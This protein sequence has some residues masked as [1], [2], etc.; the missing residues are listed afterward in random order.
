MSTEIS[1]SLSSARITMRWNEPYV[2]EGINKK[3]FVSLPK[4]VYRGWKLAADGSQH[5][6]IQL[7]GDSVGQDHVAVVRLET[8]DTLTISMAANA[9]PISL[10]AVSGQTVKLA[11]QASYAVGSE[12][13]A[14][15]VAIP[16]TEWNDLE[17][18]QQ[19]ELVVLG[20]VAVPTLDEV[21]PAADVTHAGRNEAWEAIAPGMV[22]WAP[23]IKNGG[24][25][26]A[27][28][29]QA[30]PWDLSGGSGGTWA[31]NSS[32]GNQ[33]LQLSCTVGGSG[34]TKTA[35]Q[36]LDVPIRYAKHVRLLLKYQAAQTI[37]SG[38]FDATVRFRAADGSFTDVVRTVRSVGA[39][40]SS[41]VAFDEIFAIPF[42]YTQVGGIVLGTDNLVVASSSVALRVDDVQLF[43]ETQ[44][45]LA[46]RPEQ[47]S[48][49]PLVANGMFLTDPSAGAAASTGRIQW[50]STG[51]G[52][53]V[54]GRADGSLTDPQPQL[55]VRGA[56]V[57]SNL[58]V[59][60]GLHGIGIMPNGIGVRGDGTGTGFGVLGVGSGST[61][62]LPTQTHQGVIGIGGNNADGH[63]VVG[64][65]TY[66]GAAG[67]TAGGT[68]HGVIALGGLFG[69]SAVATNANGIGLGGS[70]GDAGYGVQGGI[71]STATNGTGGMFSGKGSG[72]GAIGYASGAGAGVLGYGAWSGT[73][74]F[75]P[76]AGVAGFAGADAPGG[77]FHG[78]GIGSGVLAYGGT[79]AN[80]GEFYGGGAGSGVYAQAGATGWGILVKGAGAGDYNSDSS[81]THC[82]L[83]AVAG[84]DGAGVLGLGGAS[85]TNATGGLFFGKGTGLGARGQS[86]T[87]G[88]VGV[89]PVGLKGISAGTGVTGGGDESVFVEGNVGVFGNGYRAGWLRPTT[90]GIGLVIRGDDG[91]GVYHAVAAGVQ[92]DTKAA[93]DVAVSGHSGSATALREIAVQ[94]NGAVYLL[95]GNEDR[96]LGH[97][98]KLVPANTPKAWA[99]VWV[100]TGADPTSFTGFNVTS[101]SK[102]VDG[103]ALV[104]QLASAMVDAQSYSVICSAEATSEWLGS[105]GGAPYTAVYSVYFDTRQP[106]QFYISGF[107]VGAG[108]MYRLNFATPPGGFA[109][110]LDFMVMGLQ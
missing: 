8:G 76:G 27:S 55:T 96:N 104:V 2:T 110:V 100:P 79:N 32:A 72:S 75:T 16:L 53:L 94:T 78:S 97:T 99:K 64:I 88:V 39:A 70:G 24:F 23:L 10:V 103:L 3:L 17:L 74:V 15:L 91:H 12:T 25:E 28:A 36:A 107:Y 84:P 5:K 47:D 92:I 60:S 18:S 80:G 82:A 4:G 89:A 98:N 69:V 49:G 14:K 54:F 29:S 105:G 85:A 19:S 68:T 1:S 48:K 59:T 52:S 87:F 35:Q 21:I 83:I 57:V 38:N 37:A 46:A 101:V 34:I 77:E 30:Y 102:T 66:S 6:A 73:K 51:D 50:V 40:D 90:G 22:A 33:F 62:T 45:V 86:S 63:G 56:L 65:A 11:I 109:V 95:G 7:V 71:L 31:I 58:T 41:Y 42:G 26:W 13:T 44:D 81:A 9:T 67:V 108:G 93:G 43:L 61:A 106:D 20:T